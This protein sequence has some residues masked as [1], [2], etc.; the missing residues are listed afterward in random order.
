MCVVLGMMGG[1]IFIILQ[2]IFLVDFAHVWAEK[3][4]ELTHM[5]HT[6]TYTH[7]HRHAHTYIHTS[8]H[9]HTDTQHTGTDIELRD[10]GEYSSPM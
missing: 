1:I 9:A 10:G 2:I 3:V 5:T 6:H 4:L 8:T 7:T